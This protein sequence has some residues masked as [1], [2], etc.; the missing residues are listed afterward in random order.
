MKKGSVLIKSIFVFLILC[1]F[2]INVSAQTHHKKVQGKSSVENF[3][4]S[5]SGKIEGEVIRVDLHFIDDKLFA[6]YTTPIKSTALK[7]LSSPDKKD[8]PWILAEKVADT[9]RRNISKF[10]ISKENIKGIVVVKTDGPSTKIKL[11]EDYPAGVSKFAIHSFKKEIALFPD[12]SESPRYHIELIFPNLKNTTKTEVF[13]N[14]EIKRILG[15]QEK[16]PVDTAVEAKL[17]DLEE[18]YREAM[19]QEFAEEKEYMIN[20]W[21]FSKVV[22]IEFN[23]KAYVILSNKSQEYTGGAHDYEQ[24]KY[25]AFDMNNQKSLHLENLTAID[26]IEL[27]TLI[28]NQFR[29]DFDL[30]SD[31]NLD[32]ILFENYL[33]PGENF[34]FDK[35]GIY[36]VYNPY[37]V[38]PYSLQDFEVFIPYGKLRGTLVEEFAKRMGLSPDTAV[39]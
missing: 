31:G 11:T 36:F 2:F 15:L 14:K 10:W 23:E 37:E 29:K 24:K 32:D 35:Q 16:L 7:V 27:Q 18:D 6:K 17:E 21:Q 34:R 12:D 38:G 26:T 25:Y 39:N 33:K 5:F 3:Y 13:F 20:D 9:S 19:D 8:D 4:K 1:G 30:G 28:E 22:N